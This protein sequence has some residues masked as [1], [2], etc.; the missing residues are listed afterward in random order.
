VRAHLENADG[1]LRSA[2]ASTEEEAA[3]AATD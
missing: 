3:R 2:G 1:T